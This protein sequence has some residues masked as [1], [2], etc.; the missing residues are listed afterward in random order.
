MP[1]KRKKIY[2]DVPYLLRNAAKNI[3]AM[4]DSDEKKWFIYD[5]FDVEGLMRLLE[6]AKTDT[7]TTSQFARPTLPYPKKN[8]ERNVFDSNDVLC[9]FKIALNY[10]GLEVDIPI[11]DGVI[12]RVRVQG[13]RGAQRSGAYIGHNNETPAGFIQNFKSGFSSN[14]KYE[15]NNLLFGNYSN[16][17]LPQSSDKQVA[18]SEVVK[19]PYSTKSEDHGLSF[20]KKQQERDAEL[21]KEYEKAAHI[22]KNEFLCSSMAE[23]NHPYFVKKTISNNYGL[24]QDRYGNLLMPLFDVSGKFWS[25]QRIFKNGDKMI[26]ALLSKAQKQNNEKIYAKKRGNFYIVT[27]GTAYDSKTATLSNQILSSV[28]EVFL[29]E[30]FAT[31]VS[32]HEASGMPTVVGVDVGNLEYVVRGVQEQFPHLHI[33]IAAD[34]DLKNEKE[35]SRNIGKEKAFYIKNHYKNVSICMPVFNAIEVD[36]MCSDFNDLRKSRGLAEVKKQL[37]EIL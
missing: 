9:K 34:N 20:N 28:G 26:G 11:M 29:C 16:S 21:A 31:A 19:A 17:S 12:H 32:V 15:S 4:W 35:G 10:A 27:D 30:G 36:S 2:V 8:I 14:W 18:N 1:R 22:L 3:G 24:R 37:K 13:D 33:I 6:R 25:V 5:T 7:N 23:I